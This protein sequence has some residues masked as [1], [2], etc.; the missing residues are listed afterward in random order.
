M[1]IRVLFVCL[2]N[3]CRSPTAEGVFRALVDREGL[4]DI[5][6]CDS[7]GTSDWHIGGPPDPRAR[8]AAKGRGY[9]LE[10]L[11]AR[12]ATGRDFEDF[13]FVIAMDHSNHRNLAAIAPPGREDRLHMMLSFAPG[14]GIEEVPDPY[15]GEGD[16]FET[17]LDMLEAASTGLLDHIRNGRLSE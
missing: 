12:Q 9:D 5:I 10:P 11:R 13:D 4:S 2:G 16:G 1:S 3:I 6:T 17:V 14:L 7:A 8:Q 15:Y